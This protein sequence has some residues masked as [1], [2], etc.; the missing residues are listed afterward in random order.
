MRLVLTFIMIASS[1]S[2]DVVDLRSPQDLESAQWALSGKCTGD[3]LEMRRCEWIQKNAKAKL[4]GKTLVISSAAQKNETWNLEP[5]KKPIVAPGKMAPADPF[6]KPLNASVVWSEALPLTGGSKLYELQV[7]SGEKAHGKA[8]AWVERVKARA[9][10]EYVIAVNQGRK[11]YSYQV[12]AFRAYD[13]CKGAVLGANG[14]HEWHKPTADV[15]TCVKADKPE[16]II[17]KMTT[18]KD[19]RAELPLQLTTSQLQ[20]GMLPLRKKAERCFYNFG[21][22]GNAY[23]RFVIDKDGAVKTHKQL[24]DFTNTPTGQC[25]DEA[26][27][28]LTFPKFQQGV[29]EIDYP[30]SLQ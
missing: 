28:G 21:V 29:A 1:A 19:P 22:P 5:S 11:G 16:K 3:Q 18:T 20:D 7:N 30:I 23:L 10:F 6:K 25:I 13:P 27:K 9:K 12:K 26:A 14:T 8:E 24:G 17:A 2:A 15:K 4:A